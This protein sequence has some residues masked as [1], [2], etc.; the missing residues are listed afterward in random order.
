LYEWESCGFIP[1]RGYIL[2]EMNRAPWNPA[3]VQIELCIA[4]CVLCV[5]DAQTLSGRHWV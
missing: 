3:H 1:M 2:E 5:I 4:S